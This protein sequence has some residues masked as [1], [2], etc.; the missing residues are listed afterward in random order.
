MKKL[1]LVFFVIAVL[2]GFT[3][4]AIADQIYYE[5][6]A[7]TV[8]KTYLLDATPP[9]WLKIILNGL[10]ANTNMDNIGLA[11]RDSSFNEILIVFIKTSGYIHIMSPY[12]N[13]GDTRLGQWQDGT[14]IYIKFGTDKITVYLGDPLITNT[15]Y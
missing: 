4:T 3:G 1:V 8:D 13:V 9:L 10:V 7:T 11:F 12:F 2:T 14:E 6:P 15:S 5:I